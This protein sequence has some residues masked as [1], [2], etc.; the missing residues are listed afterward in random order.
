MNQETMKWW[1]GGEYLQEMYHVR[2]EDIK[3][4]LHMTFHE[5]I[6]KSVRRKA[7]RRPAGK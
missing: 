6:D 7:K 5:E 4:E 3:E 2:K 1:L